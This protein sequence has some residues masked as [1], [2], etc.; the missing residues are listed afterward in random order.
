ME[1][2]LKNMELQ[3]ALNMQMEMP[4]FEISFFRLLQKFLATFRIVHGAI[5]IEVENLAPM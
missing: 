5:L 3:K 1:L 2:S 4:F